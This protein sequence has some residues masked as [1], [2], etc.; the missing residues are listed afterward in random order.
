MN[1]QNIECLLNQL[2]NAEKFTLLIKLQLLRNI[3]RNRID[4]VFTF[5]LKE[6]EKVRTTKITMSKTKKNI[7]KFGDDHYI[8]NGFLVDH[9]IENHCLFSSFMIEVELV[10]LF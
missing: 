4:D 2:A 7:K 9:N 6:W 1:Q 5:E 3:N 10:Y 8:E